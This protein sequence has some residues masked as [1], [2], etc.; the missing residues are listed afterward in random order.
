VRHVPCARVAL[1]LATAVAACHRGGA[2]A[3]VL[4]DNSASESDTGIVRVVGVEAAASVV[5]EIDGARQS[6][7]LDGPAALRRVDGLRVAVT[8][9]RAGAR[10]TVRRFAVLSANGVPAVDGMLAKDGDATVLITID[11][12]RH[13]LVNPPAL[14]RENAGHRAW[15]SGPLDREIVAFGIIQ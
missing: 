12:V 15:V 1:V 7:T 10:L 13:R 9:A 8:G 3:A 11:G 4:R 2:Q 14:L 5:L 6:I